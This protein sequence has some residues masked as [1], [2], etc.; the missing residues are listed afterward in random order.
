MLLRLGNFYRCRLQIPPI[1]R[2]VSVAKFAD[3]S[4]C[5]S[6]IQF[7]ADCV[8]C[9][10]F[11]PMPTSNSGGNSSGNNFGSADCKRGRRKGGM[12]KTSDS[13]KN[14]FRHPST[15]FAQGKD[16]Q[17]VS[18]LFS[19]L[20]DNFQKRPFVHNSVCSQFVE[21]LFAILAE[22]SQFCLRSF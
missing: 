8:G 19:P 10:S 15:N 7:Q 9:R 4:P 20:F 11:V 17:K 14:I 21:G 18:K 1:L 12:S 22:C 16:R 5:A 13:V 6:S 2:S 3:K